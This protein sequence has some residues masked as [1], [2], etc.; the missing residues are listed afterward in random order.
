MALAGKIKSKDR[1]IGSNVK[2]KVTKNK[3]TGKQRTVQF[4]IYYD[5]G[6]DDLGSC[7]DFLVDEGYW[8]KKGDRILAKDLGMEGTRK[9]LIVDIEGE[10]GAAKRVYETAQVCWQ[11]IEESLKLDRKPKYE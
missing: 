5:Y 3:L 4:P 2:V 11:D 1:V 10:I 7:I 8:L 6:A 9:K